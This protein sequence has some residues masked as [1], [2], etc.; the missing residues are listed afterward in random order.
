MKKVTA[1]FFLIIYSSIA[2]DLTLNFHFCDNHFKKISVLNFGGKT[3]CSCNDHAVPMPCCKDKAPYCKDKLY[4]AKSDNHITAQQST[5]QKNI[6]FT[7]KP[8]AVIEDMANFNFRNNSSICLPTPVN[9]RSCPTPIFL[10]NR[11]L[12]I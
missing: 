6:S 8:I 3:N 5:L 2:L 9:K 4:A 7:L 12:R 1:I 10:L 11:V